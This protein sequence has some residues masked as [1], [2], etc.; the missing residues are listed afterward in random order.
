MKQLTLLSQ[1][2]LTLESCTKPS[3]IVG[4]HILSYT[5][6]T[7]E[8]PT[9]PFQLLKQRVLEVLDQHPWLTKRVKTRL[10][11]QA[12]DRGLEPTFAVDQHL[13]QLPGTYTRI[14]LHTS[15]ALLQQQS[16]SRDLPLWD[17]H[18]ASSLQFK[19]AGKRCFAL[20]TRFH[21]ALID[22]LEG[23]SF[24]SKLFEFS[25]K[26]R[27]LFQIKCPII[28]CDHIDKKTPLATIKT[29]AKKLARRIGMDPRILAQHYID[30]TA[31]TITSAPA[32]ASIFERKL[33]D[34]V[35]F[36]ALSLSIEAIETAFNAKTMTEIEDAMLCIIS[37]GLQAYLRAIPNQ[38][39][40]AAALVAL[41]PSHL[42]HPN[43]NEDLNQPRF[44]NR[45]YNLP[46]HTLDVHQQLYAIHKQ[47]NAYSSG[48]KPIPIGQPSVAPAISALGRAIQ[49]GVHASLARSSQRHFN[50]IVNT[51]TGSQIPMFLGN[52]E[53]QE[54]YWSSPIYDGMGLAINMTSYRNSL[55]VSFTSSVNIVPSPNS[56]SKAICNAFFEFTNTRA[57]TVKASNQ[58]SSSDGCADLSR[59]DLSRPDLKECE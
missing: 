35:T 37:H 24:T 54:Q 11:A 46:L 4:L 58:S 29:E 34:G 17:I 25:T 7:S 55:Q 53:L 18:C 36:G 3:H 27:P 16:L 28:V 26:P 21:V 57:A 50:L 41:I 22:P 39:I 15:V 13:K 6:S 47:T 48:H 30:Q 32:N 2:L 23:E 56:L 49:H 38:Q 10:H 12:F 14:E 8:A 44:Y 42:P 9:Q 40:P 52:T 43:L 19:V 31:A 59:P 51:A 5:D 45:F 20:I 1:A 33:S